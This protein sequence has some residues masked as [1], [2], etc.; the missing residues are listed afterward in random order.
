MS[1][2]M[3]S[4]ETKQ[5]STDRGESSTREG[6]P[7]LI[8][9]FVSTVAKRLQYLGYVAVAGSAANLLGRFHWLAELTCHF[10][11]QLL[12]A[13]LVAAGL[14]IIARSWKQA[15]LFLVTACYQA[16]VVASLFFPPTPPPGYTNDVVGAESVSATGDSISRTT[17][18]VL[19]ANVL[20]SNQEFRALIELV[21]RT[22]P[23]VIVA[24]EVN[25]HWIDE[26]AELSAEYP[27][28]L[29]DPY[30]GNFG[31]ALFSRLPLEDPQIVLLPPDLPAVVARVFNGKANSLTLIGAHVLPP[32]SAYGAKS[33]DDALEKLSELAIE[34]SPVAIVGDLN[35]SPWSPAFDSL[36]RQGHLVDTR[37]GHGNHASWPV[38]ALPM[39]IPIDHGLISPELICVK[40]AVQP[41]I[42]SDHLPVR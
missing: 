8:P 16:I 24:I 28:Q 29:A 32:I 14:A 7:P 15:A 11:W 42:G 18:R 5:V 23:D 36:L 4:V 10:R 37:R 33:R 6:R 38:G 9:S 22:D 1:G 35:C 31:I 19:V 30:Q 13:L 41:S 40:R 3:D 25:Q 39:M 12:A 26:M 2:S 17:I 34:I 21:Q 27:F 20:T